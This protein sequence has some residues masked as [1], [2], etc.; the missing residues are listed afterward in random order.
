M[1]SRKH[2]AMLGYK[3]GKAIMVMAE[4]SHLHTT[5]ALLLSKLR[6]GKQKNRA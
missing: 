2:H 6:K 4:K 5:E 3:K 1:D